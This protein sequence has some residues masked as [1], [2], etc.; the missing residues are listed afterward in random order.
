M[1]HE[2]IVRLLVTI[3]PL[4]VTP[5]LTLKYTKYRSLRYQNNSMIHSNTKLSNMK[6]LSILISI[7]MNRASGLYLLLGFLTVS[8]TTN[9]FAQE[10]EVDSVHMD[11][12]FPQKGK[13]LFTFATGVPYIAIGEYAYGFTDRFSVGVLV[14]VTPSIPGY[15]LRLNTILYKNGNSRVYARVPLLYYPQTK[16]LGGEPW[17]LTWPVVNYEKTFE[18]GL[19]FSVGGGIVAAACVNDMLDVLGIAEHKHGSLEQAFITSPVHHGETNDH[20]S[21][22]DGHHMEGNAGQ[23]NLVHNDEEGFMGDLW[24]TVQ[25]GVAFPI[26][27]KCM[28]QAE[29]AAV[30]K[31]FSIA[32]DEWVGGSPVIM[33]VGISHAF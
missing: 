13:S 30:L 24:N 1:L 9:C 25:M 16:G 18:S 5:L 31:G 6:T 22:D 4:H 23:V 26:S 8:I 33:T 32:G 7:L 15:G 27:K 29:I 14:G 10:A 20:H 28:F 11:H 2:A 3:P 21:Y 12:L 19:R 17:L